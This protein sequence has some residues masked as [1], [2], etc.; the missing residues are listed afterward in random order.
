MSPSNLQISIGFFNNNGNLLKE[1]EIGKLLSPSKNFLDID[2]NSIINQENLDSGNIS[3]YSVISKID[4][5]KMPTRIGHQLIYGAGGLKSSI[6]VSLFN[7]N[8]FTPNNK[9]SFKWGQIISGG[10][11]DS[12]VGIV[13]DP[14]ENPNITS[15]EA[16]VKF[17]DSDGLFLEKTW[18]IKNGTAKKFNAN[19][20]FNLNS[21][22]S[23][24]YYWCT[25]D[26][27]HYGLNFFSTS[28]NKLTK[29]TSGDHGF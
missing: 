28:Y 11:Y 9:K 20:L 5:G 14:N 18:K 22:K 15:H 27:E 4:S 21:K 7:S 1:I 24:K 2:I 8:L 13:A 26:A 6:A 17:Y 19:D 29:H 12:F 3:T 10:D 23:T 16:N 25:I